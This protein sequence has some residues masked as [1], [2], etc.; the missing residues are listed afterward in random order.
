MFARLKQWLL[1]TGLTYVVLVG[2]GIKAGVPHTVIAALPLSIMLWQWIDAIRAWWWLRGVAKL[3]EPTFTQAQAQ[4]ADGSPAQHG[5]P[6][7]RLLEAANRVFPKSVDPRRPIVLI[8]FPES[9]STPSTPFILRMPQGRRAVFFPEGLLSLPP[10]AQ[11]FIVA[12]E[13]THYCLRKTWHHLF[14]RALFWA[15]SAAALA[16]TILPFHASQFALLAFATTW[17]ASLFLV[18]V[19]SRYKERITDKGAVRIVLELAT[20]QQQQQHTQKDVDWGNIVA[21]TFEALIPKRAKLLRNYGRAIWWPGSV[22]FSDSHPPPITRAHAVRK[23]V[24]RFRE[25]EA[26]AVAARR[27]Y[28][29]RCSAKGRLCECGSGHWFGACCGRMPKFNV[30]P[31]RC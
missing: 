24:L 1:R 2:L 25:T 26:R 9:S 23:W 7:D 29:E 8:I 15:S 27:K 30:T 21:Q 13:V 16:T 18:H 28:L 10:Q 20:E 3:L 12:H 17:A 14:P 11:H 4:R 6:F 19:V 5:S 31:W 22:S